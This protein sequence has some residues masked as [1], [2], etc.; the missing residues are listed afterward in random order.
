MKYSILHK[1]II[2][3]SLPRLH[4]SSVSKDL[5]ILLFLVGTGE[6]FDMGK[7][8]YQVIVSNAEFEHAYGV[9]PF[10]FLIFEI[11]QLQNNIIEKDEVLKTPRKPIRIS[12]KV[13]VGNYAKDVAKEIEE[14]V[15][16]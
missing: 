12:Y 5:A 15:P 2:A 8:I 11:L 14:V 9:L 16:T 1:I 13:F 4:I 7:I 10:S 3:N 6:P